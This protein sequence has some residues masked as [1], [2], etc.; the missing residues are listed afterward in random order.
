MSPLDRG[1][2]SPS[3]QPYVAN[4]ESLE[5]A[6]V[7]LDTERRLSND[8]DPSQ[9]KENQTLGFSWSIA[10][11]ILAWYLLSSMCNNVLKGLLKEF[12]FPCFLTLANQ[13]PA[14]TTH[15]VCRPLALP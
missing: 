10:L 11:A 9:K 1:A 13:V 2:Q 6:T 8:K 4:K 3:R 5:M 14:V 7:S 15:A 12:P